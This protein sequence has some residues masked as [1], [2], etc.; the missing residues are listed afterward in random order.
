MAGLTAYAFFPPP[1]I[2]PSLVNQ[3]PRNA[4]SRTFRSI[5]FHRLAYTESQA[6]PSDSLSGLRYESSFGAPTQDSGTTQA[7]VNG[8]EGAKA[9]EFVSGGAFHHWHSP[10]GYGLPA[11]KPENGLDSAYTNDKSA[12]RSKSALIALQT[13]PQHRSPRNSRTSLPHFTPVQSSVLSRKRKL[14]EE[15]VPDS[16]SK[17]ARVLE[18][19]PALRMQRLADEV[20]DTPQQQ[21]SR[22]PLKVIH[23]SPSTPLN[24]PA[25]TGMLLVRETEKRVQKRSKLGHDATCV[26]G[27]LL[28]GELRQKRV[29]YIPSGLS[30]DSVQRDR[31]QALGKGK[32]LELPTTDISLSLHELSRSAHRGIVTSTQ[33]DATH[34][35]QSFFGLSN[36]T[37]TN[38]PAPIRAKAG[39]R[40]TGSHDDLSPEGMNL[41]WKSSSRRS[42]SPSI[43]D[44]MRAQTV[45]IVAPLDLSFSTDGSKSISQPG[46]MA[47]IDSKARPMSSTHDSSTRDD[48]TREPELAL[49]TTNWSDSWGTTPT[50]QKR[51]V[52]EAER[53][54]ETLSGRD[55]TRTA[56]DRSANSGQGESCPIS[57]A[58]GSFFPL[59]CGISCSDI[60]G[61]NRVRYVHTNAQSDWEIRKWPVHES[62]A[63]DLHL[64]VIP[65]HPCQYAHRTHRATQ[66]A[67]QSGSKAC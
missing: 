58:P 9:Q 27:D 55:V 44:R 3:S 50:G 4:T 22:N 28:D 57:L 61:I 37:T 24:R 42:P 67:C 29:R 43:K 32:S 39:V 2:R 7:P 1:S 47:A 54:G 59:I 23:P 12:E 21:Q 6:T 26:D 11:V 52:S 8:Q 31:S 49:D 30:R 45:P 35:D 20:V 63:I 41:A 40:K 19:N 46:T 53:T 65:G 25:A 16:T 64:S 34:L 51:M 18:K 15:S 13:A 48:S 17:E 10:T 14:L 62:I 60:D 56:S 33:K 36:E 5:H 66:H 38:W